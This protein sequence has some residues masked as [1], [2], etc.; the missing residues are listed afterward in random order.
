MVSRFVPLICGR[1]PIGVETIAD[2]KQ[3][4]FGGNTAGN[5]SWG[6]KSRG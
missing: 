6:Q 1:I 3:E 2:F 4:G 5:N